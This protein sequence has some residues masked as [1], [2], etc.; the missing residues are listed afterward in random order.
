MSAKHELDNPPFDFAQGRQ[1]NIPP[2]GLGD[3]FQNAHQ[4]RQCFWGNRLRT[5]RKC[6]FGVGMAFDYQ[7]VRSGCDSG[8]AHRWYKMRVPRSVR[9]VNHYRKV[10]LVV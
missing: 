5:V 4:L 8:F 10:G 9:G 1:L 3:A 6:V 7:S 2:D